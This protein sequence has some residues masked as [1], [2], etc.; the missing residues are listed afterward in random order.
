MRSSNYET[1]FV[2]AIQRML[3]DKP[4]RVPVGT[5]ITQQSVIEETGLSRSV[6]STIRRSYPEIITFILN[7]Q[8]QQSQTKNAYTLKALS[9]Y[10]EALERLISNN[11]IRVDKG[12]KINIFNVTLEAGRAVG[13]I[14]QTRNNNAAIIQ[15]IHDARM[16]SGE[17]ASNKYENR[18]LDALDR[19]KSGNPKVVSKQAKPTQNAV[20]IEA[21]LCI[22]YIS[23]NKQELGC[24]I[25]KIK[26]AKQIHQAAI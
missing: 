9:V 17:C 10:F 19:I 6:I 7:A 22:R 8:N 12:S 5:K 26:E 25:S 14:R 20:A 4:I 1:V 18:L 13:S 15:A 16:D 2:N 11:P 24:V 21:G 23:T 3:V